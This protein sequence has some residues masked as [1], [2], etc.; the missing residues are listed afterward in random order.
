MNS[1]SACW[2]P[3]ARWTP[4][5]EDLRRQVQTFLSSSDIG[6]KGPDVEASR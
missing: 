5:Q 4:L 3:V 6:V 2:T 1:A